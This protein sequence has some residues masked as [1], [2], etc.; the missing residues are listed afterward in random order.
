MFMKYLLKML[1][2]MELSINIKQW[3]VKKIKKFKIWKDKLKD[4]KMKFIKLI[5]DTMN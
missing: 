1:I 5:W 4:I 2:M 3:L